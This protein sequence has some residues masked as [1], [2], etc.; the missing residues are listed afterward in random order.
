MLIVSLLRY[1][2]LAREARAEPDG[3][4]IKAING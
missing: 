1:K 4:L 3:A 2:A